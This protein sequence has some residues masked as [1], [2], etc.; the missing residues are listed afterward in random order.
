M[1]RTAAPPKRPQTAARRPGTA[2]ITRNGFSTQYAVKKREL[3]PP[4][5]MRI[6]TGREHFG[7]FPS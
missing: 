2:E 7:Q 4:G 3:V 5:P 6:R 1:P